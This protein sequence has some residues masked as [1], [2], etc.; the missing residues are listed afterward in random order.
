MPVAVQGQ[1]LPL[2]V[3][4]T[5]AITEVVDKS[6]WFMMAIQS[7]PVGYDIVIPTLTTRSDGF[8][9][10]RSRPACWLGHSYYIRTKGMVGLF[11]RTSIPIHI[12]SNPR[13][14]LPFVSERSKSNGPKKRVCGSVVHSY[15]GS[16]R[17]LFNPSHANCRQ[18]FL[19][20]RSCHSHFV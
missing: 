19:R 13:L 11:A 1:G 7:I 20:R 16:W 18:L 4:A 5:C 6:I 8:K 17:A 9:K 10:I 14:A 3:T 15:G 2:W 12:L